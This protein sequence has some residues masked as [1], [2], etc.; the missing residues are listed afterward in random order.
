MKNILLEEQKG[1]N[2]MARISGIAS[3]QEIHPSPAL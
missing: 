2:V 3:V 1:S